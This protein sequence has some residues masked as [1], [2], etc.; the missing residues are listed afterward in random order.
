MKTIHE[1]LKGP[2]RWGHRPRSPRAGDGRQR[3]GG[4]GADAGVRAGHVGRPPARGEAVRD[5]VA[6]PIAGRRRGRRGRT[7]VHRGVTAR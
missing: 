4:S 2:E 5:C 7:A 1:V 3:S 6:L